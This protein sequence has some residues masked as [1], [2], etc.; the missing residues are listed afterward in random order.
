VKAVAPA[1]RILVV[2]DTHLSPRTPEADANWTAVVALVSGGEFELVV[3]VGDLTVDAPSAAAELTHARHHL[4][5]LSVPWV[6]VPGNHD[7]GDNAGVSSGPAT[8]A[9]LVERWAEAIGPDRWDVAV[10]GW[11]LLGVNAQLF[12]S[13]SPAEAAQW[14][15][16][17]EK[18]GPLPPDHPTVFVCH[19]PLT[20]AADE[21]AAAPRH[22]FVPAPA[23]ERLQ[24]QFAGRRVPVV[25][26][27][28][29]HQFRVLERDHRRHVWAPTT[30][31]VLPDDAQ[32]TLGVKQ[33]G[34]VALDLAA[35]GTV[36]QEL[37]RPPGMAQL[38]LTVDI[39]DPYA[40]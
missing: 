36:N 27:G 1:R 24:A 33:C 18:L 35:D 19:K 32:Q 2:S 22:R 4:D 15:W 28:H 34:V 25:V 12:G 16:L 37:M 26:S 30:W 40:H 5:A 29:V 6:A 3:H 9:P 23:R 13:E 39:P 38:T 20:A 8:S 10:D 7:V 21:L 11:T 17:D 31:A 14:A